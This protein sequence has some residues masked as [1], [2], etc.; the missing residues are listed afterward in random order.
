MVRE[1]AKNW[2]DAWVGYEG[3]PGLGDNFPN[4]GNCVPRG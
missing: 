3:V 2:G 4:L 1:E